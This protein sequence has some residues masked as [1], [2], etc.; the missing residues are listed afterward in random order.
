MKL[1]IMSTLERVIKPSDIIER[2]SA[3]S[4]L[5]KCNDYGTRYLDDSPIVRYYIIIPTRSDFDGED[6]RGGYMYI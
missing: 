5:S 3:R 1:G 6:R 2:L 4:L